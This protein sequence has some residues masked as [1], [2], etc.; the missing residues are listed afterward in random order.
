[1]SLRKKLEALD[2][3]GS[4]IR[5]GLVGVG[6]MGRGFIAQVAGIPGI[7][8]VAAADLYLERTIEAFREAGQDPVKGLNGHPDRPAV[9]DDAGELARSEKVD[10]VVEA[11]GVTEIGARV[12]YDAIHEG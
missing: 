4:P 2:R 9:T 10:V 3:A 6:Q 11:T 8:V 5:V 1:M 12:A 7:E